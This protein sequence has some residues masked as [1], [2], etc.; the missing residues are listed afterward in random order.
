MLKKV[1]VKNIIIGKQFEISDNYKEFLSIIKQKNIKIN[2]V[3]EGAKINIEKNLFFNVLWPNS[4]QEIIQ[5]SINNNS[6]VCKLNYKN[7]T[8]L[9][10]GDIEETTE[11]VLISKYNILKVG[12]HGSNTSSTQEFLDLIKP[13]VALIGVG[14]N[15]KFGHP[16]EEILKRLNSIN[17][18]I[19][20]TD[21]MGEIE[22]TIDDKGKIKVKKLLE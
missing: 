6:L 2:V 18:K 14:Q 22:I 20:R 5:N 1:K 21:R 11:K 3:E 15:N 19:Y 12:H 7:F 17:C 13:K 8:M 4:K 16:N 9:F 10:T